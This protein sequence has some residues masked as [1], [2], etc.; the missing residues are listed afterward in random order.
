MARNKKIKVLF[1]APYPIEGPSTRYRIEP[2]FAYLKNMDIKYKFRPFMCTEYYRI[3]YKKGNCILKTAYLFQSIFNRGLDF[4]RVFWYDTV[5]IHIESL[6]IGPPFMEWFF[7]KLKKTIIF[8]FEDAVYLPRE[9]KIANFFKMPGKF[10]K[11]IKMSDH[12][13]VCNNYLKE[14][15]FPY[16][17]N[18][19]VIPT[20]I[21]T[22]KFKPLI[23]N[24]IHVEKIIIGW[25]GSHTTASFLLELIDVFQRLAEKYKF[26]LKIVGAGKDINIPGVEV[27]N[28]EWELDRDIED[29]NSLDIGVYPLPDN[30]SSKARTPFK[31]IRYMSAGIPCVVSAVGAN[32]DIVKDGV[33]G[34]LVRTEAEWVEKLSKLIE[35][36]D[37]RHKIGLS[38][39][40]TVEE[41][42]S[43][44]A[45]V[46]KFLAVVKST[47]K[48]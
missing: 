1:L 40:K 42:Y 8:D 6:P 14:I 38:G 44:E 25:I 34:F 13:I 23:P 9:N 12:V 45:A 21:D 37:L 11:I 31:T 27:I 32:V 36:S 39:R 7:K 41:K 16:N 17:K 15:L 20:P 48:I 29:F 2:Y 18:I 47:V 28:K 43:L 35:D 22:Y 33:N 10:F 26:T 19:T 24:D 3:F 46:P 4:I 5:F 30:E